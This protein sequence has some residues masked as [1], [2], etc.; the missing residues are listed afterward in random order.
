MEL[1]LVH[2]NSFAKT[3]S[4]SDFDTSDELFVL[5]KQVNEFMKDDVPVFMIL[6]SMKAEI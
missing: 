5:A 4:F 1:N 6:S 3:M 2:I